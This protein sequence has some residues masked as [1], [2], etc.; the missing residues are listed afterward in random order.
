MLTRIERYRLASLSHQTLQ[1]CQECLGLGRS[2]YSYDLRELKKK[3]KGASV[4]LQDIKSV[5]DGSIYCPGSPHS[6]MMR[7]DS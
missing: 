5:R 1:Q 4:I 3:E 6:R 7:S 2:V